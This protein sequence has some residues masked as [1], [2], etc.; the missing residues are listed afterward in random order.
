MA[1][2]IDVS[3]SRR[4]SLGNE[5]FVRT[6]MFGS[7]WTKLK[8][9]VI[10]GMNGG[11]TFSST[12]LMGLCAGTTNTFN[13][14]SCDGF[15]GIAALTYPTAPSWTF[16]ASP[17]GYTN[18]SGLK[19]EVHRVGSGAATVTAGNTTPA[20]A[21]SDAGSAMSM[22]SITITKSLGWSHL[23]AV[24]AHANTIAQS[25]LPANFDYPF[26]INLENENGTSYVWGLQ[27][28]DTATTEISW[29]GNPLL[30]SFSFIWG[31]ASPTLDIAHIGVVRYL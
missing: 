17:N 7:Q 23:I 5:E 9:G 22:W 6:M 14:T 3:G 30:D 20:W 25:V 1:N 4:L 28:D 2:I 31:T 26:V 24:E 29:A 11:A 10:M 19:K 8:I 13:S 27:A 16:A 15:F 12:L 21:F 18:A